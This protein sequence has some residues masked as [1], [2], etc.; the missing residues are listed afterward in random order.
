MNKRNFSSI[1]YVKSQCLDPVVYGE[2]DSC[3]INQAPAMEFNIDPST[4]RP[5][6]S[7][8]SIIRS[9]DAVEQQAAFAQLNEFKS[10]FLPADI[11]NETAFRYAFPSRCQLPSEIA[12]INEHFV[13]MRM[14]EEEN[15][16]NSELLAKQQEEDELLMKKREEFIES[17][18]NEK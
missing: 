15:K 6:S 4:G 10:A 12:S 16:R 1:G 17:L 7:I 3:P 9:Q 11:D 18:K 2:R 13:K 5:M 8:T 14:E